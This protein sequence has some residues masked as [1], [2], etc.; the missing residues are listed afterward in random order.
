MRVPLLTVLANHATVIELILPEV[1][2]RVVVTVNV[3]LGQSVVGGWLLHTL[4][5]T[6][7]KQRQKKLQPVGDIVMQYN[8]AASIST[9]FTIHTLKK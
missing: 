3:D 8:M 2:L 5:D 6:R 7:L 4:V 9:L 1:A